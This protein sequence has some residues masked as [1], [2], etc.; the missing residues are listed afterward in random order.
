MRFNK[1]NNFDARLKSSNIILSKHKNRKPIIIYCEEKDVNF[2]FLLLDSHTISIVILNLKQRLKLNNQDS[3]FL[4]I[5]KSVIPCPTET[6]LSLYNK[7][8]DKDGYLYIDVKK[9]NTF[10]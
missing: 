9:E 5:N 10:G 3:I 2:K 4:F 1:M 6:I 8:K 7:Y